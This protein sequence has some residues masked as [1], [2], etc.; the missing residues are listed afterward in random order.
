MEPRHIAVQVIWLS[1]FWWVSWVHLNLWTT[2]GAAGKDRWNCRV[3]HLGLPWSKARSGTK[4]L[5]W[6]LHFSQF[7][8]PLGQMTFHFCKRP[9]PVCG[10]HHDLVSFQYNS[11]THVFQAFSRRFLVTSFSVN[12]HCAVSFKNCVWRLSRRLHGSSAHR[13]YIT[14]E[15]TWFGPSLLIE[16]HFSRHTPSRVATSKHSLI[17]P[18]F[19]PVNYF[20]YIYFFLPG[21][22][23]TCTPTRLLNR[24]LVQSPA[25]CSC[26]VNGRCDYCYLL[27]QVPNRVNPKYISTEHNLFIMSRV[28][29]TN[30]Y[31]NVHLISW[32]RQQRN[33]SETPTGAGKHL[34][35][36]GWAGEEQ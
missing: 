7:H 17:I 36:V 19:S 30:L 9:P 26:L 11:P 15:S 22:L 3:F 24:C 10:I 35:W 21:L 6:I 1:I 31:L 13:I 32:A 5:Y 27:A 12:G 33:K 2:W 28:Y 4:C 18:C 16:L 20:P 34:R 25:Q 29:M 14:Q 8:F 23:S